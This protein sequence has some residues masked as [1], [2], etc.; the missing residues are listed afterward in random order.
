MLCCLHV[1]IEPS[2]SKGQRKENILDA[3]AVTNIVPAHHAPLILMPL[4]TFDNLERSSSNSVCYHG[5]PI[6]RWAHLR[7]HT[8]EHHLRS[9]RLERRPSAHQRCSPRDPKD[10]GVEEGAEDPLCRDAESIWILISGGCERYGKDIL[11]A[12]SED[13]LRDQDGI[14]TTILLP[15]PQR[16]TAEV[17]EQGWGRRV[18]GAC[19]SAGASRTDSAPGGEESLLKRNLISDSSPDPEPFPLIY[20]L[21]LDERYLLLRTPTGRLRT[22]AHLVPPPF[23]SFVLHCVIAE[24]SINPIVST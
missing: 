4:G 15:C 22:K 10:P 16:R 20:E 8:H 23:F 7:L 5:A 18:C 14:L 17:A 12:L 11:D 21:V 1:L 6:R 19:N 24:L 2:E 9:T 13:Q 3:V